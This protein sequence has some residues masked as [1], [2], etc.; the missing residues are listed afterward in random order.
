L[1]DSLNCPE[2]AG[3][4][5]EIWLS[6][7]MVPILNLERVIEYA[8]LLDNATTVAKVGFFLEQHREQ[9]NVGEQHLK[10]L[11]NKIP[12]KTHYLERSKRTPGKLIKRW[13][14]IVPEKVLNES[15]SSLIFNI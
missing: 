2:Y 11:Q 5:E 1:V 8:L 4:F 13:H 6:F 9:F 14:L 3:D 15:G 7:A 12:Q 10:I